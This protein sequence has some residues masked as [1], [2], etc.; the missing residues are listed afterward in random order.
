MTDFRDLIDVD[1]LSPEERARLERVHNLLVRAGPP[2]ELPPSLLE[3]PRGARSAEILQFPLLPR[4]RLAV[5]AIIAAAVALVAFGG[6]YLLG[7]RHTGSA[8]ATERVV[9]MH[10]P[11]AT[12]IL[13]IA[14]P[15]AVGNWPMEMEVIGLPAQQRGSEAYYELWV[16]RHGKPSEPC[17]QFR[18]R[19][20]TTQL[21]FTVP[22]DFKGV[23]GWVITRQRPGQSAP[24]PVVLTT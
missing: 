24:G 20:V 14:K 11:A 7:H 12:A 10:G 8:F 17:G 5:A 21:R 9:T 18:V 13:R 6:G 1:S 16:T 3:P 19:G 23:D 15:D 4:R 22:W 2:P